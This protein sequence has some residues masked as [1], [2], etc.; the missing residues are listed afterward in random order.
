MKTLSRFLVSGPRLQYFVPTPPS[1][2]QKASWI[3]REG[4]GKAVTDT[5]NGKSYW[6]C[7]ICYDNPVPQPLAIEKTESTTPAIRHLCKRHNYD[8]KGQRYESKGEKRQHEIGDLRDQTKRLKEA[9]EKSVDVEKW[10]LAYVRWIVSG[11]QSLRNAT[12]P[13]FKTLLTFE[14]PALEGLIPTSP[15][16]AHKYVVDHYRASKPKVV[17]A[18]SRAQSSISISFDGWLADNSLDM[19]GITAHYLDEDLRAKSVLLGLIPMYGAHCGSTV[20]E[21]LLTTMREYKVSDRLGYFIADNASNND[22]ALCQVAQELDVKPARQRLRCHAHVINPVAKPVLYGTD[23]DCIEDAKLSAR[24]CGLDVK[25]EVDN[26]IASFQQAVRSKDDTIRLVAWRK[27]GPLGECHNLICHVKASPRRRRYF[28]AKQREADPDCRIYTAVINGGIRWNA[29]LDMIERAVQLRDALQLYQDHYISDA[30]DR[31]DMADYLTSEDWRELCDLIQLLG[32]LKDVSK[33]CQTKTVDGNDGALWQILTSFEW[34]LSKF[35]ELK[36][37]TSSEHLLAC[38]NLGWKKLN[39]YYSL[40]DDS[41]AYL[42]AVYLHPSY[43][44]AWFEKNWTSNRLIFTITSNIIDIKTLP[45][46]YAVV[47]SAD[48][49]RGS[50]N[51]LSVE[52]Q[53]R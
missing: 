6:L 20:A 32:P 12:S 44:M 19:L 15:Q 16:T 36:C 18:L 23:I 11:N 14:R 21:Q 46:Q 40:A 31:L 30:A 33:K 5:R 22:T 25:E 42:L 28:E 8:K 27:K 9:Q 13:E 17:A 41:L 43:K 51:A 24:R 29:D 47:L 37:Q 3:W 52:Y 38:I 39:K 50:I 35:E 48:T 2:R 1:K 53:V 4:I 7:R 45:V 10:R 34:L 26:G 49:S